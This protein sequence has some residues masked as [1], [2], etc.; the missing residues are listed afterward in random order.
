MGLGE[1]DAAGFP[2][3]TLGPWFLSLGEGRSKPVPADT[4]SGAATAEGHLPAHVGAATWAPATSTR[5]GYSS[6]RTRATSTSLPV[7]HASTPAARTS[8]PLP[9][10]SDL[11]GN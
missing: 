11:D 10:E 8:L 6:I 2:R 3:P 4:N 5:T 7:R 9:G 1:P